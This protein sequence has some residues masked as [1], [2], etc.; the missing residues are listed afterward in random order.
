[1]KKIITLNTKTVIPYKDFVIVAG[2][3]ENKIFKAF[4]FT[5]DDWLRSQ[6]GEV[7]HSRKDNF[8]CI[9]DSDESLEECISY[10][11]EQI[12]KFKTDKS[13]KHG[14]KSISFE[15]W[16]NQDNQIDLRMPITC[17]LS[18]KEKLTLQE[19]QEF[20]NYIHKKCLEARNID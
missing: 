16:F 18:F 12:D 15:E 17:S 3:T 7:V 2:K 14:K 20:I 10:M 1:M 5:K 9:V 13:I 8:L 11:K 4:S 6:S 19:W